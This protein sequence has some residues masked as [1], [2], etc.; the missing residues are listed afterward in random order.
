MNRNGLIAKFN[1]V[2][3][4]H[5]IDSGVHK[6]IGTGIQLTD[7]LIFN[8]TFSITLLI[9][10]GEFFI[11]VIFSADFWRWVCLCWLLFFV[12]CLL[13]IIDIHVYDPWYLLLVFLFILCISM[14]VD[15][16]IY[17]SNVRLMHCFPKLIYHPIY[18]PIP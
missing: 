8:T 14:G 15:A 13:C 5:H 7:A 3:H 11:L 1:N 2:E 16:F 17:Y 10:I 18:F 12:Y 9:L 4:P 6:I